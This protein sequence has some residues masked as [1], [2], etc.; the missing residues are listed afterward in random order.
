MKK[1]YFRGLFF[2]LPS[3]GPDVQ[4]RPSLHQGPRVRL[5]L[6]LERLVER[7]QPV[8]VLGV[9][10]RAPVKDKLQGPEIGAAGRPMQEGV[11]G[12]VG[13]HGVSGE[14]GGQQGADLEVS[15]NG[16]KKKTSLFREK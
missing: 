15:E 4:P 11:L 14:S 7:G 3:G 2:F 1:Y 9:G 16:V 5:R 8:Q 6:S 10:I 12:Q 13:V